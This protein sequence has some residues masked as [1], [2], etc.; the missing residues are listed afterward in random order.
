[1]SIPSSVPADTAIPIPVQ[2]EFIVSCGR[3]IRYIKVH[4]KSMG[5]IPEW[6][7]GAGEA[8]WI[9]VDEIVFK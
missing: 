8:A 2:H 9:F 5:T 1:M 3:E 4:A 6:H 7:D